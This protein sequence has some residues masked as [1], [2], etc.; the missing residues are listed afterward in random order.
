MPA[1]VIVPSGLCSPRMVLVAHADLKYADA[2]APPHCAMR[3]LS[4]RD[5]SELRARPAALIVEVT[6]ARDSQRGSGANA[7]PPRLGFAA[8][9]ETAGGGTFSAP[10]PPAVL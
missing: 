2:H 5:F 8:M 9:P 7:N 3:P 10:F 1:F 4:S 6:P